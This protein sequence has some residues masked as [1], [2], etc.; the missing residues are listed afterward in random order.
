MKYGS[1]D[2]E[3]LKKT[4]GDFFQNGP[5]GDIRVYWYMIYPYKDGEDHYLDK[6]S[7][8]DVRK[9]VIN[10]LYDK[11]F[12][13]R[14]SIVEKTE[15]LI[16]E[17]WDYGLPDKEQERDVFQALAWDT[18]MFLKNNCCWDYE[19]TREVGES[20]TDM[21][22]KTYGL[23]RTPD[24]REELSCLLK[25][26]L[27]DKSLP[28]KLQAELEELQMRMMHC[29]PP[30]RTPEIS[31]K[32]PYELRFYVRWIQELSEAYY[33]L[34]AKTYLYLKQHKVLQDY[35]V[36]KFQEYRSMACHEVVSDIMAYIQSREEVYKSMMAVMGKEH[37]EPGE[38]ISAP[39]WN[40]IR[41]IEPGC[42]EA[43]ALGKGLYL[44]EALDVFYDSWL[45]L[46]LEQ[47]KERQSIM[48][49]RQLT[50]LLCETEPELFHKYQSQPAAQEHGREKPARPR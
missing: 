39:D 30:E 11:C 18:T 26:Y 40:Y 42:I 6:F 49:T 1:E 22:R 41:D 32:N 48:S 27:E 2:F 31:I 9:N 34:P 15:T 33:T 50:D 3:Q 35:I 37:L 17:I 46:Q 13:K 29:P 38:R 8:A 36:P 12:G 23:I 24:G 14:H 25:G 43:I 4:V 7:K 16:G 5:L 45:A 10:F 19:Q 21:V 20:D 44:G 28:V 47:G